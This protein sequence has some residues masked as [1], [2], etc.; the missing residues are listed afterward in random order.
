MDD[1]PFI[2]SAA[3]G[4]G[5][6]RSLAEHRPCSET[7]KAMLGLLAGVGT[8]PAASAMWRPTLTVARA[9]GPGLSEA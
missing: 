4:P 1:A 6:W 7:S 3:P 5:G 2:Q 8:W 9:A